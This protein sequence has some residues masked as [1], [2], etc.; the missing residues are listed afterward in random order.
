MTMTTKKLMATA[1]WG[2]GTTKTETFDLESERIVWIV[3]LKEW[4]EKN[5]YKAPTITK[6]EYEV[7]PTLKP[8]FKFNSDGVKSSCDQY[9]NIDGIHYEC[10]ASDPGT[11]DEVRAEAKQKGLKCRMIKGEL[12]REVKV[13]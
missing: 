6:G 1:T 7:E 10:Y 12:Y 13:E 2:N 8:T 11:F 3:E 5:G 4:C 9:R